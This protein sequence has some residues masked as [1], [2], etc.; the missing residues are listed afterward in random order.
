MIYLKKSFINSLMY[1]LIKNN[2]QFK[3]FKSST[4]YSPKTIMEQHNTVYSDNITENDIFK[5]SYIPSE[6]ITNHY[7]NF[8]SD[9]NKIM[10]E[11]LIQLDELSVYF[12]MN[13]DKEDIIKLNS[14]DMKSY[15]SKDTICEVKDSTKLILEKGIKLD[16]Y[17]NMKTM[18]LYGVNND[19]LSGFIL[20]KEMFPELEYL[21]KYSFKTTF[22][23]VKEELLDKYYYSIDQ[24]KM[25]VKSLTFD[26]TDILTYEKLTNLFHQFLSFEKSVK[27]YSIKDIMIIMNIY[28]E[29][30]NIISF[31]HKCIEDYLNKNKVKSENNEY[32]LSVIN[33]FIDISKQKPI[34]IDEFNKLIIKE[35]EER[36]SLLA[37]KDSKTKNIIV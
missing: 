32:Y 29:D 18:K 11:K 13:D 31:Y 33:P 12:K 25:M 30:D 24:A 2:S 23:K 19:S 34:M 10:V 35:Q 28:Q 15:E 21:D 7:L 27:T 3:V 5:F 36:K 16:L 26:D 4:E 37:D 20:I 8:I 6:L 22:N 9:D 17:Y 1:Y 14:I